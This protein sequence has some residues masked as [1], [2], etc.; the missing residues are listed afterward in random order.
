MRNYILHLGN[1]IYVDYF[2]E[3]ALKVQFFLPF[4]EGYITT[5][6][7]KILGGGSSHLNPLLGPCPSAT[8]A[9]YSQTASVQEHLGVGDLSQAHTAHI[10]LKYT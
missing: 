3:L 4:T 9:S 10:Y 8:G 7:F 2:Y 1:E 6:I 5:L